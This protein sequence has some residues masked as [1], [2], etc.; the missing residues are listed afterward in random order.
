M[1]LA[2]VVLL[3]AAGAASAY[4][5]RDLQRLKTT[6]NC[7]DCDLSGAVLIHWSLEGA[8]LAGANLSGAN[9]TDSFLAGANLAGAN[10]S[11]AILEAANLAGANLFHAKLSRANLFFT[12]LAGAT[13]VDGT[14]CQRRSSGWCK[15]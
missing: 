10:L 2:I 9:L 8:D 1:A 11:N 14:R 7:V 4:D 13:W 6:G 12:G 3:V 15:E 5:E